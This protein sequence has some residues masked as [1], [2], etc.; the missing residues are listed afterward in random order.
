MASFALPHTQ[1]RVGARLDAE[2]ARGLDAHAVPERENR[3]RWITSPARCE[4][5]ASDFERLVADAE[6]PPR[7]ISASAPFRREAVV[8]ARDE[9]FALA[10]ALRNAHRPP[11]PAVARARTLLTDVASPV[12]GETGLDLR[13]VTHDIRCALEDS[14]R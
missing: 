6:R 4:R 14:Q 3:A 1:F 12:Y 9:L 2:L 8:Q 13:Q 5:L 10:A 11:A 7:G